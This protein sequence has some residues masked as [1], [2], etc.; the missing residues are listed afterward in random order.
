MILSANTQFVCSGE[1]FSG[2]IPSSSNAF[3]R[4][5]ALHRRTRPNVPVPSVSPVFSRESTGC[6]LPCP[7]SL[8][9]SFAL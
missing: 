5:A 1:P 2:V 7:W 8:V 6:G 9:S 3:L 4:S